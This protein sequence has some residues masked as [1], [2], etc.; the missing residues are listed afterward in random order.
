MRCAVKTRLGRRG[1][2]LLVVW[3]CLH[4]GLQGCG[5]GEERELQ[6]GSPVF[7]Q[8]LLTAPSPLSYPRGPPTSSALATFAYVDPYAELATGVLL[9]RTCGQDE[10]QRQDIPFS[11][12][13]KDFAG[14]GTFGV[15]FELNTDCE[16]GEYPFR[17]FILDQGGRASN[18]VE[19]RYEI[20]P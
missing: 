13:T 10:E 9:V 2:C 7:I 3:A 4:L 8:L 6:G 11:F 1:P 16:V 17:L 14:V 15:R 18:E 5:G 20:E 12:V 19:L